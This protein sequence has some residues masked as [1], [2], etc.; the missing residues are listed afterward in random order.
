MHLKKKFASKNVIRKN[1]EI[2]A[3]W[4]LMG[5][6]GATGT[7]VSKSMELHQTHPI[8]ACPRVVNCYTPLTA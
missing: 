1:N 2:P 5:E 3:R 4:T 7:I 8:G 6:E